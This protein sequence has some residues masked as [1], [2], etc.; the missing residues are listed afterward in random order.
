MMT[1][2]STDDLTALPTFE[3]RLSAYLH[4]HGADLPLGE[5][6]VREARLIRELAGL[7]L[8]DQ[9]RAA[10]LAYVE[11]NPQLLLGDEWEPAPCTQVDWS[12]VFPKTTDLACDSSQAEARPTPV[13][14][15]NSVA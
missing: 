1:S 4:A 7:G 10:V 6:V 13:G 3:N 14:H 5:F 12:L 11:E 9:T 8:D 2:T 15:R